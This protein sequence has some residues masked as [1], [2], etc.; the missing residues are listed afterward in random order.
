M[1]SPHLHLTFWRNDRMVQRFAKVFE[2]PEN[3]R[4]IFLVF[5]GLRCG[6]EN[7]L[8]E[9]I[10]PKDTRNRSID[11]GLDGK[12]PGV[13]MSLRFLY[14]VTAQIHTRQTAML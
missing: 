5:V 1:I 12:F 6:I 2:D 14:V 10:I 11:K 7:A 8:Q 4:Y 9:K 13:G 3:L